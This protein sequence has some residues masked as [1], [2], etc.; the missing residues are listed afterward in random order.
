[1]VSASCHNQL[2][3]AVWRVAGSYVD[4]EYVDIEAGCGVDEAAIY[5][6]RSVGWCQRIR[7]SAELATRFVHTIVGL[8]NRYNC[9]TQSG[10]YDDS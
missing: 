3:A 6:V 2:I 5:V 9:P 1:M 8:H 10:I 7:L 4:E